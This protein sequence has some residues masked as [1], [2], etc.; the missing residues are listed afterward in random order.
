MK[1]D[2]THGTLQYFPYLK[3]CI[4]IPTSISHFLKIDSIQNSFKQ[5]WKKKVLD[6]YKKKT[7]EKLSELTENCNTQQNIYD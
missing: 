2:F 7:M 1:R 4:Y 3:K 5:Q 6:N